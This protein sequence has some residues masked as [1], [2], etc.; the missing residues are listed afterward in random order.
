M[1]DRAEQ[2]ETPL[3][4]N[5]VYC[6]PAVDGLRKL[7]PCSVDLCVT[8][9]PYP[10]VKRWHEVGLDDLAIRELVHAT[11]L[12]VYRVL[13]PSGF[14]IFNTAPVPTGNPG[15]ESL[16]STILAATLC[17]DPP[18]FRLRLRDYKIW[19]KGVT[20]PMP[21]PCYLRRPAIGHL[22]HEDVFVYIKGDWQ[23]REKRS[24]LTPEE[25][26]WLSES[27]W[28]ISPLTSAHKSED[29]KTRRSLTLPYPNELV[30][31][32]VTLH[33]LPGDVV[34]DPFCGSGTTLHVAKALGR[35]YV[36][37]DVSPACV[38][39]AT[40]YIAKAPFPLATPAGETPPFDTETAAV[41]PLFPAPSPAETIAA[42][43]PI[44]ADTTSEAAAL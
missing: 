33:S 28:R 35:Q 39:Y 37:F 3:A 36:G 12:E 4:L 24:G 10:G 34:L 32:L 30:R 6:M 29:G 11:V 17:T 19:N 7:P 16:A 9:P 5:A 38:A 8:S 14:M 41:L 13:K 31:R 1:I 21:P 22:T 25:R 26:K 27:V 43:P 20:S 15:I 2:P 44:L 40:G 42:A 23:P 18:E